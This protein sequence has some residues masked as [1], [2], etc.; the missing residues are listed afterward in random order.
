[1][2]EE[3][4]M[5]RLSFYGLDMRFSFSYML[6]YA[7]QGPFQAKNNGLLVL[8]RAQLKHKM[9]VGL[10]CQADTANFLIN[11]CPTD[12][13]RPKTDGKAAR[14]PPD[15]HK[16]LNR[17]STTSSCGAA[18]RYPQSLSKIVFLEVSVFYMRQVFGFSSSLQG[19]DVAMANDT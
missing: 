12:A 4:G 14:T 1:M 8:K 17:Y 16:D 11:A 19:N 6:R 5:K 9:R 18:R 13:N 10:R 2:R 7:G 15:H 3:N